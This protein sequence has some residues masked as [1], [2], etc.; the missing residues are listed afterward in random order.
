MTEGQAR[1]LGEYFVEAQYFNG[2]PCTA[3]LLQ[4]GNTLQIRTV[5]EKGVE[6]DPKIVEGFKML[7]AEISKAVFGERR[8]RCIFAIPA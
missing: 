3:Q 4:H 5:A 6:Q 1:K 7:G 2:T 8:F